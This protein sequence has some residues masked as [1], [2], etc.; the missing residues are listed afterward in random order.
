VLLASYEVLLAIDCT[1]STPVYCNKQAV[2][3]KWQKGYLNLEDFSKKLLPK[4]FP[5]SNVTKKS[6]KP[7]K[8]HVGVLEIEDLRG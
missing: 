2:T 4:Y 6:G 7:G 5:Y 8:V 3:L 1:F